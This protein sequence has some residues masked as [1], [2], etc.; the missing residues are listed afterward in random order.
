MQRCLDLAERGRGLVGTNPLV[1]AVLVRE[2][3]MIAEGW[4]AAFG[5]D[6]AE[7]M[8]IKKFDQEVQPNDVLYVNLEPCCHQG[9]T[10]PCTDIIIE[11]GIKN[12]VYG[13]RDPN[14]AVAGQGIA[15]L[16]ESGIEVKGPVLPELCR[17]LNRG[18]VSLQEQG[19][20]YITLKRAQTID[21]KIASPDGSQ[22]QITSQKQDEWSHTYLRAKHDAILV[23][24]QTV[25]AD[26]PQLTVRCHPE[27]S[28]R[29]N[30]KIDQ[31]LAH[32][33]RLILDPQ[34]RT[35]LDVNV[36]NGDLAAGTIIIADREAASENEKELLERGVRILRIPQQDGAFDWRVLWSMLTTPEEDFCGITGI[37][38][39]GGPKTWK[40]FKKA[41]FM[42]EEVVLVGDNGGP[43]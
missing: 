22:K 23:G 35:P 42:D 1:G 21:G 26:D 14:S 36:V 37:L 34:L 27:R 20:P 7:R 12:V 32:P 4:H 19:R 10:P 25:I 5:A 33:L 24:V 18:Y 43:L 2:G 17:R 28:R 6:H 30:K 40:S 13:M 38:V 15:L 11:S 16:R 8:L 31:T 3:S 41:G 39:E 29:M 9:K